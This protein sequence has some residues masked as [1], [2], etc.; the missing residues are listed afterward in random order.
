MGIKLETRLNG[1]RKLDA[2]KPGQDFVAAG[3]A[4]HVSASVEVQDGESVA[5]LMDRINVLVAQEINGNCSIDARN[6]VFDMD[7]D[8]HGYSQAALVARIHFPKTTQQLQGEIDAEIRRIEKAIHRR[9]NPSPTQQKRKQKQ[10]QR[11]HERQQALSKLTK[12]ERK[13]LGV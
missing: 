1:L 6:V 11:E 8:Y 12:Q 10:Q 13:I 2:S 9:D 5:E 4:L 3:I 7:F